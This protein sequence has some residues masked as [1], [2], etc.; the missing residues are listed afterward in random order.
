VAGRYRQLMRNGLS[1]GAES[2]QTVAVGFPR[3]EDGPQ[4]ELL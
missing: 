1:S 2:A 3:V 4:Q